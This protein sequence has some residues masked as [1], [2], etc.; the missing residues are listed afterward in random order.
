MS[1]IDMHSTYGAM[2]IGTFFAT[3]FQGILSVQAYVYYESFP[4]D[5]WQLKSLVGFLWCLDLTHLVLT[6]QTC[7]YYLIDNWGND[8]A[9]LESTIEL[10]LHLVLVGAATILCQGFFLHRVWTFSKGN[11]LLVGILGLMCLTTVGLDIDMSVALSQNRS[12]ATINAGEGKVIAMF[13][14]GA[15]VDLFIAILLCWYLQQGRSHFE[16]TNFMLARVIQYT[17]A[18]GLATSLLAIGCIAAYLIKPNSF[19][20]IGMHFSLERMY[21][22][23]LLASLNSRRNLRSMRFNRTELEGDCPADAPRV[24]LCCI[25]GPA[26]HGANGNR[27]QAARF[28][29]G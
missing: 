25:S 23:A 22:N 7:Y 12:V 1:D 24:C 14:I 27:R 9:L 4:G 28:C 3:L 15:I 21:T 20:F 16:R 26:G 10:D 11:W 18:T 8:L 29:E 2:L 17:V 6:C 13:A 19:V 5:P